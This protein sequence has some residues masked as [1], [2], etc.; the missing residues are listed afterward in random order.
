MTP[1]SSTGTESTSQIAVFLGDAPREGRKKLLAIGIQYTPTPGDLNPEFPQLRHTHKDIRAFSKLC[2]EHLFNE[3]VVMLDTPDHPKSFQPTYHNIVRQL[4]MLVRGARPGDKL[5]FCYSGHGIQMPTDD[6]G[7]ED[8]LDEHIVPVDYNVE[9]FIS[10]NL[11]RSILVDYLPPGVSLLVIAD[12]CHSG[13]ILDLR[14]NWYIVEAALSGP[15]PFP[16]ISPIETLVDTYLERVATSSWLVPQADVVCFSAAEDASE[17]YE[18][19]HYSYIRFLLTVYGK[20]PRI[21]IAQAFKQIERSMRTRAPAGRPV[22][23]PQLS[24]DNRDLDLNRPL[25]D[26]F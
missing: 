19:R 11:L 20:N 25:C 1:A 6:P 26:Y 18:A 22:Q 17:A 13:T 4:L 16:P 14:H 21:T 12:A 5:V 23:R 9:G 2:A 3:R 10:D 15:R 7:E 8:G 24:S